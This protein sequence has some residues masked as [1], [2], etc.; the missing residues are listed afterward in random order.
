VRITV[1][2]R[3]P[4]VVKDYPT[5]RTSSIGWVDF[6]SAPPPPGLPYLDADNPG[7]SDA[8]TKAALQVLLALRRGVGSGESDRGRRRLRRSP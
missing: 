4:V 5:A 1:A 6:A 2:E 3:V 8:P 7:P